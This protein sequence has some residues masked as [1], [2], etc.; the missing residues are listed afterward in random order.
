[1]RRVFINF[2]PFYVAIDVE[3]RLIPLTRDFR[4]GSMS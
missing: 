2:H 4:E 3:R 1:M